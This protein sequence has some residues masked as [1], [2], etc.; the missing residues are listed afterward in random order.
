MS[1]LKNKKLYLSGPIEFGDNSFNW[2]TNVIDTLT[3]RFEIDV[4][5]PFSD[6][7]Q[8]WAPDIITAKQRGDFDTVTEIAKQFCEKDL[9]IVDRTDILCAYVP[10]KVSSVGTTHEIINASNLKKPVILVA[11]GD[12]RTI[13]AWFFAFIPH[14]HMMNNWEELYVFLDD[15]NKGSMKDHRRWK[16]LYDLL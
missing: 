15:V 4:Y 2:R 9:K 10:Y 11:D 16:Y 7:K 5:D 3:N 13:S 6:P 14:S 12:K 8:Q 1:V